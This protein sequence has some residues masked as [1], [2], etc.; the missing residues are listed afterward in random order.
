MTTLDVH[1]RILI[2]LIITFIV[3]ILYDP[4]VEQFTGNPMVSPLVTDEEYIRDVKNIAAY[5]GDY[6]G[7][8]Y[9]YL[10]AQKFNP[11][12][13][14]AVDPFWEPST[15][16]DVESVSER[17]RNDIHVYLLSAEKL[18]DR[19]YPKAIKQGSLYGIS[20]SMNE[21]GTITIYYKNDGFVRKYL[22]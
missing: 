12:T 4:I 2:F 10:R 8:I 7:G 17:T 5:V 19:K 15:A 16:K 21:D 14:S 3:Y 18:L 9:L 6:V 20:H 22:V 13:K 1:Q 11:V